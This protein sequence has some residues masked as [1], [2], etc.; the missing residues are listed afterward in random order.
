MYYMEIKNINLI[1]VI[2]I[3]FL[4]Y[5]SLQNL[6]NFED[7]QNIKSGKKPYLWQYWDNKEGVE[8]PAYIKLC[9]KT[10]D[11]KCSN[12]F[13]IIRLNEDNILKYLPEMVYYQKELNNMIIAHKVDIYRIF[14]LYKYGG[15]YLDADIICLRDPIEIIDK[16]KYVDFVG[17]GCTGEICK[18]GY[19]HPSNWILA[20]K[21]SSI[22][23][24]KTLGKILNKITKEKK[25]LEYHEIGKE[26]LWK[27]LEKLIN[28][29]SYKYIHYPNK[30]DGSRD[31]DGLWVDSNRV[32]SNENIEYED[33]EN[34]MFFVFYNSDTTDDIKKL[35]AE[36]LLNKDYNFTKFLKRA[37]QE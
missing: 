3:L 10:V 13:E 33:E 32:F 1:L 6:K 28:I 29:Y 23:M 36:E 21:K 16:L 18:N 8:T 11:L 26:I 31:K 15:L 14:L 20:S 12:S 25:K 4:I 22:L 34:M 37:L 35:S 7:F 27:E 19:G 17:F 24:G 9:L 30:I 5:Q 2:L